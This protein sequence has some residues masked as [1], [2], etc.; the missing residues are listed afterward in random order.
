[1]IWVLVCCRYLPVF[2]L[3]VAACSVSLP[4]GLRVLF[5]AV[6][7]GRTVPSTHCRITSP[8]KLFM[9]PLPFTP[10]C[11]ATTGLHCA[12][13]IF[14]LS[15]CACLLLLGLHLGPLPRHAFIL[16]VLSAC[17]AALLRLFSRQAPGW[18][19]PTWRAGGLARRLDLPS[20]SSPADIPLL[21]L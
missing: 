17:C 21:P 10:A 19:P 15:A 2:H 13:L 4:P 11:T 3:T 20:A 9:P 14:Y 7:R 1:L 5:G 18:C 6:D 16:W 8:E 12:Y